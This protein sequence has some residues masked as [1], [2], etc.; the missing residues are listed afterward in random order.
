VPPNTRMQPTGRIGAEFHPGGTLR[1][2]R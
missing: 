2:R 1:W